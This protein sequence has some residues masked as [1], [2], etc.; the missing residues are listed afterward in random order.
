[1]EVEATVQLLRFKELAMPTIFTEEEKRRQYL[2]CHDGENPEVLMQAVVAECWGY[3]KEFYGAPH[4]EALTSCFVRL[5]DH[6][7]LREC[8]DCGRPMGADAPAFSTVE[9]GC[10]PSCLACGLGVIIDCRLDDLVDTMTVPYTF[11]DGVKIEQLVLEW[12]TQ[13]KKLLGNLYFG[14]GHPDHPFHSAREAL[15]VLGLFAVK[16]AWREVG[17]S[18][19]EPAN[20]DWHPD[21]ERG[22]RLV[23]DAAG[24]QVSLMTM[25]ES[26]FTTLGEW[27]HDGGSLWISLDMTYRCQNYGCGRPLGPDSAIY[28][29]AA[30][31]SGHGM[32]LSC[33]TLRM[34]DAFARGGTAGQYLMPIGDRAGIH[35]KLL[36]M[37]AGLW[38]SER[39]WSPSGLWGREAS[40]QGQGGTKGSEPL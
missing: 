5:G 27:M 39:S 13:E 12:P 6:S 4:E 35:L 22:W 19:I 8:H 14:Y 15:L 36:S 7:D 9:E 31:V 23:L 37:V 29:P 32:C 33:G 17:G 38:G 30:E 40:R 21:P 20:L 34:T 24:K 18:T 25:L 28:K 16:P 26:Q 2:P 11:R 3:I 10:E 1:L